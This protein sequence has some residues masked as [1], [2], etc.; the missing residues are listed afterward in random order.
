MSTIRT[1]VADTETAAS[2]EF[3]A[4][5]AFL[6]GIEGTKD[7]DASKK[8]SSE[9]DED[10]HEDAPEGE[11]DDTEGSD[12]DSP[13]TDDEDGES[14]EDDE[15]TEKAFADDGA[16]VK[17]KV[18]GEEKEVAVKDLT[19]LYGQEAAL[20]R[21]SQEVAEQRKAAEAE[22]QKHVSALQVLLTRAQEKA[23]PFKS[24]DWMALAKDPNITAEE[25]SQLRTMAQAAFEEESFLSQ[26]LDGFMQEVQKQTHA[27]RIESAKACVTALTTPG[28]E[29]KPN[30]LHIDGWNDKTYDETRAF[31][32]KMGLPPETVNTL[33]DPAA[34]KMMHMAMLFAKGA[35]KV[36][37][38]K[39]VNKTP[40]KIVK[41][42]SSP[43]AAR[44]EAP[45]ANRKAAIKALRANPN[46]SGAAANA[47]MASFGADDSE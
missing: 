32:V 25:A 26:N 39:K 24:I 37:V 2:E 40:K 46:K 38:T 14:G 8:P 7:E 30:P 36:V 4:T 27:Q 42:S 21:K 1:D 35:S 23:A 20:T 3:D 19:R 18:D 34:I 9:E 6:K 29:D 28:T 12:K 13:E 44:S 31:G 11:S 15:G 43:V 10:E 22:S 17:L 47:F 16:Y 5:S 33:T 45:T 41:T